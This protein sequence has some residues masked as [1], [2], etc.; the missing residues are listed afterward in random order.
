M[1]DTCPAC[2]TGSLEIFFSIKQVPVIINILS[3]SREEAIHRPKGDIDLGFCHHCGH[4]YNRSFDLQLLDYSGEYDNS[5]HFSATFRAFA[6]ELAD[7]MVHERGWTNSELVEV[8]CG[9]AD[10]LKMLCDQGGNRGIGYDPS[11]ESVDWQSIG[12]RG[13]EIKL[14]RGYFGKGDTDI[15]GDR[16]ICQHVLEHI[17][18]PAQFL[19]DIITSRSTLSNHSA[20]FEVPNVLYTLRDFGIWDIIYE[21][22]SYFSPQSL[23]HLFNRLGYEVSSCEEVYGSQFLSLHAQFENSEPGELDSDLS[24]LAALVDEFGRT[25]RD[26]TAYW[27]NFLAPARAGEK[28]VVVWGAGSK[29]ITFLNM[30]TDGQGI[31]YIIDQNPAKV[32]RYVAGTGQKIETPEFLKSYQPDQVIIMNPLYKEEI[33]AGLRE[34]GL[35][36]EI[37]VA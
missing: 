3:S 22:C 23:S 6:E 32:G 17:E 8:G 37:V 34:M 31:D 19:R 10:F 20:Y 16:V 25:F 12:Q 30:M 35:T 15:P 27:K 29:G 28:K 14:V 9:K 5:L 24:D 36:P 21:H 18:T 26:K 33:S 11:I 4:I 7:S 13:G 2:E 1:S